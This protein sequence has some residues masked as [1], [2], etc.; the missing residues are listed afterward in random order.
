MTEIVLGSSEGAGSLEPCR[1]LAWGERRSMP[2]GWGFDGEGA[3]TEMIRSQGTGDSG[4]PGH[5]GHQDPWCGPKH[6]GV[7]VAVTDDLAKAGEQLLKPV[8]ER[9]GRALLEELDPWGDETP[10]RIEDRT[11]GLD[12]TPKV[13]IIIYGGLS[14]YGRTGHHGH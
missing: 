5:Q 1:L 6:I 9:H 13:T 12:K 2:S 8:E 4:R 14:R 10:Y 7:F 3:C 11:L